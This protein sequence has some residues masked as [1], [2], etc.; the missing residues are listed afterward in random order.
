[1]SKEWYANLFSRRAPTREEAIALNRVPRSKQSRFATLMRNG[2]P[3]VAALSALGISIAGLAGAFNPSSGS[4]DQED[5]SGAPSGAP[6]GMPSDGSSGMPGDG[7]SGMPDD[8]S[9]GMP[10]TTPNYYPDGPFYYH[11]PNDPNAYPSG[12]AGIPSGMSADEIPWYL[13][14]GYLPER[15]FTGSLSQRKKV[16]GSGRTDGRHKRAE[17]VRKVMREKGLSLPQA[18]KYVKEHNLY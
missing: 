10:G 14:T 8:G 1:M 3:V 6:S 12:P 13:E 7:S 2:L 4:N 9:S 16:Y 15:Y 17:I 11:D 18:S 5:S